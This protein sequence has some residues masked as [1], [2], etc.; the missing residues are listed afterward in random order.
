MRQVLAHAL[1]H[2]A[3]AVVQHTVHAADRGAG[4]AGLAAN[5]AVDLALQ[6]AP[7]HSIALL[8]R[9]QL[10]HGAQ[11]VKKADALIQAVQSQ[12]RLIQGGV[13]FI[14]LHSVKAHSGAPTSFFV[15]FVFV[16]SWH[17]LIF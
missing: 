4:C 13:T 7:G 15:R 11:V 14:L 12:D 8:H 17:L 10:G 16:R 1:G 5:L 2:A 6:K 9:A 3:G